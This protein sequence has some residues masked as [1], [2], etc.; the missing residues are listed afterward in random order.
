MDAAQDLSMIAGFLIRERCDQMTEDRLLLDFG[1]PQSAAGWTAIN[2]AVMGGVS[3][4]GIATTPDGT[5]LFTGHVRSEN[6]GGFASI[7]SQAQEWDL[8]DYSGIALRVRGDG[9]RFKV[10][11]KVDASLGGHMYRAPFETSAGEWQTVR[12]PFASFEASFRGRAV[13]DAPALDPAGVA[14]I[15]V[16]VSDRQFGPFRLELAWIAAFL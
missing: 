3:T 8:G 7:R 1:E 6:S 4:S 16:L 5:A 15:G 14:S 11:L 9:K 10:N 2:D 13:L 12:L